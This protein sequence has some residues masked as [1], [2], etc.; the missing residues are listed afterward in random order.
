MWNLILRIVVFVLLCS[1][2]SA[3][4]TKNEPLNV[5]LCDLVANPAKYNGKLVRVRGS[6]MQGELRNV[7]SDL[8]LRTRCEPLP[9]T[10]HAS[11]ML[12]GSKAYVTFVGKVILEPSTTNFRA[13]RTGKY[14]PGIRLVVQEESDIRD[15]QILNGPI[16][17][18]L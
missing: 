5:S 3:A 7:S 1:L 13:S 10:L 14:H 12:L 16:L 15:Q 6:Y 4:G 18:N 2:F 8:N 17:R 11:S 9:V